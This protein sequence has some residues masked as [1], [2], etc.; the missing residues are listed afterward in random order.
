[1]MYSDNYHLSDKKAIALRK[2]MCS[3]INSPYYH[4][5]EPAPFVFLTKIIFTPDDGYAKTNPLVFSS[6]FIFFFEMA[7]SYTGGII[8]G[9]E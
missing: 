1:M 6:G 7:L 3:Q 8:I 2:T 5:L 4:Y 9:S